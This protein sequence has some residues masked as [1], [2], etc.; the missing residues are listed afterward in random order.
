MSIS[1]NTVRASV[2]KVAAIHNFQFFC[3][4]SICILRFDECLGAFLFAVV[5]HTLSEQRLSNVSNRFGLKRRLSLIR[6]KTLSF[7][8][9]DVCCGCCA[10]FTWAEYQNG[11]LQ[12]HHGCIRTASN[13]GSCA[14]AGAKGISCRSR[15]Q[16][17][18]KLHCVRLRLKVS[19]QTIGREQF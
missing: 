19:L 16:M 5:G 4:A 7:Y 9:L 6:V 12:L 8:F 10:A 3:K 14:S 13:I 11:A 1:G 2:V 18:W 17:V 15:V